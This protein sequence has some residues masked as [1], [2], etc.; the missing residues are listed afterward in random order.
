MIELSIIIPAYNVE[1]YIETC[2]ESIFQQGL[3]ESKFEVIIVNDGSKDGTPNIINSLANKYHN[4]RILNQAN[5]GLSVSRNNGMGIAKGEYIIFIDADDLCIPNTLSKI[6]ECA[7]YHKVDFVKGQLVRLTDR[8]IEA[9]TNLARYS[10]NADFK[11]LNVVDGQQAFVDYYDPDAS[12]VFLNMLR[13]SF[14][15]ENKMRFIEGI[16]FEDVAFTVEAYL[17]AQRVVFM[18]LSFYV[19]RQREGSIMSTMNVKKLIDM[20]FVIARNLS[21]VSRFRLTDAAQRKL[22]FSAFRSAS[23]VVWY[24]ANYRSLYPHTHEVINDLKSKIGKLHFRGDI[25]QRLFSFCINHIPYLCISIR[26]LLA[27]HKY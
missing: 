16:L 14:L 25:K 15:V 6:L 18:P 12:Y 27:R 22:R 21:L 19:Y 1:R 17:Q 11:S 26:Y 24:L 7:I 8:Q 20:N 9:E 5:G 13:R 2:V 4:I 10:C 3:D 23:V